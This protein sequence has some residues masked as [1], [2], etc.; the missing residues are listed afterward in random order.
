M[1]A[2]G[3]IIFNEKGQL[4]IVKPTYHNRGWLIP[5]GVIEEN[6]SP[7]LACIREIKEEIGLDLIPDRLLCLEYH[8]PH[9]KG[10]Q[11]E[12]EP[13]NL[14][15]EYEGIIVSLFSINKYLFP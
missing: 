14:F 13:G 2:A 3:G 9:G 15:G 8:V 12:R 6:E 5:G 10:K 11:Y 4:L 1:S 7:S